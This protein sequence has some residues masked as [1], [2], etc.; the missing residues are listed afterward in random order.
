VADFFAGGVERFA[1]NSSVGSSKT[2]LTNGRIDPT[3]PLPTQHT[4]RAA[5]KS[6]PNLGG[7]TRPES[8]APVAKPCAT[9]QYQAVRTTL[10][11]R[12]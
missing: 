6:T 8:A 4:T 1:H 10:S 2:T 3:V 12:R 5:A 11:A 9:P 7:L